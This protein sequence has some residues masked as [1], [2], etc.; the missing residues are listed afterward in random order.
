MKVQKN[1]TIEGPDL[2]LKVCIKTS[3]ISFKHRTD[4]HISSCVE[5]NRVGFFR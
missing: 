3:L 2:N 5:Y 1:V 4:L